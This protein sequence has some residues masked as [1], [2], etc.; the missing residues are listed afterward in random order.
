MTSRALYLTILLAAAGATVVAVPST[1]T[2][3]TKQEKEEKE[4]YQL[5]PEVTPAIRTACET[6]VR[7]LCMGQDPSIEKVKS[8]VLSKFFKLNKQCQMR[9]M[10]AGF[11]P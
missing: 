8:C 9:L 2:A 4:D 7:R 6:D 10:A 5:P 3:Q 11:S 1:T